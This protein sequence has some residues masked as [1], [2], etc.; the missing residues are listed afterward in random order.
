MFK[1]STAYNKEKEGIAKNNKIILGIVV[2]TISKLILCVIGDGILFI[3]P[4]NKYTILASIQATKITITTRKYI[5][6]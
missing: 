6:S 3:D 4:L 1:S 2:H 5:I